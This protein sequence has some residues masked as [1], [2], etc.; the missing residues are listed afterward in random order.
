MSPL[1]QAIGHCL[2][3]YYLLSSLLLLIGLLGVALMRQ[4]ARKL[5]VMRAIVLGLF[6]LAVLCAL[7]DWSMLHLARAKPALAPA[8]GSPV[9]VPV[10]V[11]V[12]S[13]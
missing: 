13:R 7:P 12:R 4:P 10:P 9:E 1:L 5:A 3:D 11:K 8:L 6:P 2:V